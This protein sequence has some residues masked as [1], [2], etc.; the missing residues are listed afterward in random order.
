MDPVEIV[1]RDPPSYIAR[2]I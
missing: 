2:D 1:D